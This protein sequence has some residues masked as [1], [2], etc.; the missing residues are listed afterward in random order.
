MEWRTLHNHRITGLEGE[1]DGNQAT[2]IP[3]PSSCFLMGI[4]WSLYHM[5]REEM[6]LDV[7]LLKFNIAFG[8]FLLFKTL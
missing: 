2:F 1:A 3:S 7:K 5:F 6:S 4:M 8:T